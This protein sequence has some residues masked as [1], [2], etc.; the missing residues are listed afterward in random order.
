M[1]AYNSHAVNQINV[2]DLGE[3]GS[4]LTTRRWGF[5]SGSQ[6]P[7]DYL[8]GGDAVRAQEKKAI[9]SRLK[10]T[11]QGFVLLQEKMP[12]NPQTKKRKE[13]IALNKSVTCI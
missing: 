11:I 13:R 3:R 8:E 12:R 5:T 9:A 1:E 10:C 2:W 6:I 4:C 7:K